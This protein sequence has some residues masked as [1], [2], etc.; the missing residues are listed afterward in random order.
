MKSYYYIWVKHN[1]EVPKDEFGRSFDIHHI[2]GNNKNN[3]INN[4]KCISIQEH[5]DIHFKQGDQGA[6]H[7]IRI[8]MGNVVTGW[9][10]SEETRKK[11]SQIQ[12][13]RKQTP[14]HIENARL[15]RLK[16]LHKRKKPTYS[17]EGLKR[18]KESNKNRVVSEET[19]KKRSESMKKIKKTEEWKNKISEGNKGK[20]ISDETRK[21][22]RESHLGISPSKESIE[23]MLKTRSTKVYTLYKRSEESKLKQSERMKGVKRGSYKKK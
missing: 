1:G 4:L 10:H 16:N 19:R 6:C 17:E 12:K 15:G 9:T 7:A 21:K 23:K 3:D 14:E 5:Y 8:R 18:L 20:I 13:G 11:I 22:L 2:D